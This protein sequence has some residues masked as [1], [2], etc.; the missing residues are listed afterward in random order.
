MEA[1]FDETNVREL[2]EADAGLVS[3]TRPRP[4]GYSTTVTSAAGP[5]TVEASGLA[6][7]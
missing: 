2:L 6:F 3:P 1:C 7:A 5:R 4:A